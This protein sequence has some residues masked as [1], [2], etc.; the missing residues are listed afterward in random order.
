MDE[1]GDLENTGFLLQKLQELKNWQKLQEDQLMKE[2][3]NEEIQHQAISINN[4]K[5]TG[6]ELGS[7]EDNQT[8]KDHE[9]LGFEPRS[10]RG[11]LISHDNSNEEIQP[12]AWFEGQRHMGIS[13][14]EDDFFPKPKLGKVEK[15]NETDKSLFF[16]PQVN[17][18]TKNCQNSTDTT[19]KGRYNNN[20]YVI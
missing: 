8:S 19:D 20:R 6:F 7:T 14:A 18:P 13:Y 1:T 3:Q 4:H 2:Q 10:F 17:D 5:T 9:F 11:N 16:Y 15:R 12:Q